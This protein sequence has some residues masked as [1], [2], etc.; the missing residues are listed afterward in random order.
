VTSNQ[1]T[2]SERNRRCPASRLW[3]APTG[4]E[5]ELEETGLP[6]GEGYHR[7]VLGSHEADVDQLVARLQAIAAEEIP[8]RQLKQN[9]HREGWLLVDDVVEGRL[10]WCDEGNEVG[11]PYGVVV[12]GRT[13]SWEELGRALEPYEEWRFRLELADRVEDLRPDAKVIELPSA[14]RDETTTEGRQAVTIDEVLAGFLVDQRERLSPRTYGRYE[15]VVDLLR[16]HLNNY[17]QQVLDPSEQS[18]LEAA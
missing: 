11:T 10:I 4:I 1:Q 2:I 7:S 15:S 18:R 14:S 12:D 3:R 8:R 6:T 5:V 9:P 16:S 17:G 13:L